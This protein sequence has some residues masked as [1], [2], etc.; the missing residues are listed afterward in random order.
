MD[1]E[2]KVDQIVRLKAN[3]KIHVHIIEVQ[4]QLCYAD[5]QQVWY[6]GRTHSV[7][8]YSGMFLG[9]GYEKFSAIELEAIPEES[10]EM[11][12]M[13][14]KMEEF[15]M[16]KEKAIQE[17]DFELASRNTSPAN[18]RKSIAAAAFRDEERK[19]KNILD[20]QTS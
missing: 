13:R 18:L 5:V 11:K 8:E 10:A 16:K 1:V 17:K 7:D 3:R 20:E 6:I 14:T 15:R 9:K 4:T 12:E 19:L 2:F